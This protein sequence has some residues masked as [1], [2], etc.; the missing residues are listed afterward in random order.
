MRQALLHDLRRQR[1][2]RNF[3]IHALSAIGLIALLAGLYDV[4]FP[5]MADGNGTWLVIA[6]VAV[7][8]TY[9]G[10]RSWPRPIEQ[11]YEAP[12]VK[13]SVVRGDMLEQAADH[14]VIGMQTTFDTEP[15]QII[16]RASL[17]GQFV[18]KL[19][20]G[21]FGRLNAELD[22]ALDGKS[23]AGMITKPGKTKIFPVGTV[24]VL[25]QAARCFF[26]VAYSEMDS[27]NVARSSIENMWRSLDQLWREVAIHANGG[28]VA[29]PV[30]G[31]GLARLSQILPVHDSIR[32]TIM[33]FMFA[34]RRERV[35]DELKIVVAPIDTIGSTV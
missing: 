10:A 4:F 7:A 13:I 5:E 19:Y 3:F 14:L 12:N 16:A 11:Q 22:E 35:C 27:E 21:D 2:W 33:S 25:K 1:F 26:C 28:T 8:L 24:A 17:Q 29:V 34:C 18:D 30:L 15:P 32:L 31:G 23:P 6:T 20:G 9:A